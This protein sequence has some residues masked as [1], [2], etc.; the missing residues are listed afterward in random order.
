MIV[1]YLK[2]K[3]YLIYVHVK[4]KKVNQVNQVNTF[5]ISGKTCVTFHYYYRFG[6]W[7]KIIFIKKKIKL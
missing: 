7:I 2:K 3:N 4:Q 6:L 1:F 5:Q